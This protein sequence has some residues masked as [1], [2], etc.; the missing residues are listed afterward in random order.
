MSEFGWKESGLLEIEW[1]E[2]WLLE[3]EWLQ[4]GLLDISLSSMQETTI[5][6]TC[7]QEHMFQALNTVEVFLG[8]SVSIQ[9]ALQRSSSQTAF[10]L[11][12][13]PI[14]TSLE[15]LLDMLT[16]QCQPKLMSTMFTLIIRLQITLE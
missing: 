14:Q 9:K 3:I 2:F 13:T 11:V 10:L 5:S 15:Q 12:I 6:Q 8:I 1:K 7:I 16:R 4:Y